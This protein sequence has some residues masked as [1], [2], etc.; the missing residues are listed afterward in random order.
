MSG[1][2][3]AVRDAYYELRWRPG[4]F[5]AVAVAVDLPTAPAP[6]PATEVVAV[7]ATTDVPRLYLFF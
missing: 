3:Q 7:F 1:F 6:G 4:Y 2:W 5:S